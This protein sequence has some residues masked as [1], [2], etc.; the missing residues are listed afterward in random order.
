MVGKDFLNRTQNVLAKKE[1]INSV[2]VKLDI[3]Y[4]KALIR[5]LN[6]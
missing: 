4:H 3:D 5:E 6:G 2:T 1:N